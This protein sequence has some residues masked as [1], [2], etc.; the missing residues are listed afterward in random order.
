MFSKV[1][2]VEDPVVEVNIRKTKK[3]V[4]KKKKTSL[5][6]LKD[7][8]PYKVGD[9]VRVLM[10]GRTMKCIENP[11]ILDFYKTNSSL[12]L[13]EALIVEIVCDCLVSIKPDNFTDVVDVHVLDL[14]K[15][16]HDERRTRF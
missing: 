6:S 15:C 8:N 1:E 3:K 5:S 7:M 13:G 16:Y 4:N 14:A 10:L 9:R 12:F 2:V 11:N